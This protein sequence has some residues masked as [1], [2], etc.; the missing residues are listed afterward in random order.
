M[1]Q[2]A[3]GSGKRHDVRSIIA[4][5]PRSYHNTPPHMEMRAERGRY[6]EAPKGRPSAVVSTASTIARSSPL[7]LGSEQGGKAHHSPV[8]YEEKG[9]MRNPYPGPSHRGS[10]LSREPGQRQHDGRCLYCRRYTFPPHTGRTFTSSSLLFL[11]PGSS[12]NPTQE[13]KATPTPREMSA[14]KSPLPGVPDQQTYE[15]LLQGLGAADVYR[16]LPLA[17]DPAALPRGIP[18]DPGTRTVRSC[19]LHPFIRQRS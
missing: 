16:Q 7:T 6:E 18:I 1:K 3:A 14:T 12:K 11:L 10:P 13:R 4:S 2:E 19:S 8:G 15:R 17:F 9:G 5:S